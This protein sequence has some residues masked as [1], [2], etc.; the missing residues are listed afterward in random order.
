M[1]RMKPMLDSSCFGI[2]VQNSPHAEIYYNEVYSTAIDTNI[3]GIR[4]DMSDYSYMKCNRTGDSLGI[5]YMFSG[6]NTNSRWKGNWVGFPVGTSHPN[7]SVSQYGLLIH[8]GFLGPQGDTAYPINNK[9]YGNFSQANTFTDSSDEQGV[10]FYVRDTVPYYNYTTSSFD[11]LF[12]YPTVNGA[13]V[14]TW[15]IAPDSNITSIGHECWDAGS[16]G[17]DTILGNI[18]R[19]HLIVHDSVGGLKV[20]SY[21]HKLGWVSEYKVIM[22][23]S[24]LYNDSVLK[25]FADSIHTSS[26]GKLDSVNSMIPQLSDPTIIANYQ[27]YNSGVTTTDSVESLLKIVNDL[28]LKGINNTLGSS[29]VTQLTNISKLCPF[30]YGEAVYYARSVLTN[31]D[32]VTRVFCN[33][34]EYLNHGIYGSRKERPKNKPTSAAN[35]FSKLYPNPNNGNMLLD[36]NIDGIGKLLIYNVTGNEVGNFNLPTGRN[37]IQINQNNL[38]NGIYFYRIFANDNLINNGKLVIIK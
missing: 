24:T 3:H 15:N 38:E 16:P 27:T 35:Y 13:N 17:L 4:A 32:G 9:W 14:S 29:D 12:Y 5:N 19:H 28:R 8:D 33:N 23:D 34:C 21:L 18:P 2:L 26:Y 31:I 7:V 1:Y 11:T 37:T 25:H 22:D 36:Y 6:V 20:N 30:K 10:P